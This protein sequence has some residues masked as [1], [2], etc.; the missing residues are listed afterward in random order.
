MPP[1][2]PA[3]FAFLGII[4]LSYLLGSLSPSY[5]AGRLFG[6][7]DLREHGS[8]NVGGANVWT[9]VHPWLVVPVGVVEVLKGA[10][11]VLLARAAGFDEGG[12]MLAGVCALVGHNWSV[13]LGFKGGRGTGV[14]IGVLLL[15][16][17]LQLALFALAAILGLMLG[18]TPI[19]VL[20]GL[21]LAPLSALVMDQHISVFLGCLAILGIIATKR[22]AGHGLWQTTADWPR[23]MLLR[24]LFDRDVWRRE[25]WIARRPRE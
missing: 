3:D 23:T 5:L 13:F 21:L 22:L 6:G 10:A 14:I 11:A 15:L 2:V 7:I 19:G 1:L 20:V 25:E 24:L 16:A 4:V 8:G 12:Q 18:I 9:S 17:P